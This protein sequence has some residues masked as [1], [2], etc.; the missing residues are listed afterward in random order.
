MLVVGAVLLLAAAVGAPAEGASARKGGV[1]RWSLRFDLDSVDPALA[2]LPPSRALLGASCALLFSDPDEGGAAGTRVVPEVV[3]QWGVS[4]D[5][6]VYTF[7]LKRTFHFH[8][9]APVTARSFAEAFNRDAN[10]T[11]K[12]PAVAYLHEIVG[13][14]AVIAGKATTISGVRV[15]APYRLQIRL[16]KPLGDFTARLTMPFFCPLLPNTPVDG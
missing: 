10:P 8:K 12:S 4:G 13:A 11:M 3:D 15:L 16:T 6:K 7:E 14:D 5:G 9:G 1:L 2:D